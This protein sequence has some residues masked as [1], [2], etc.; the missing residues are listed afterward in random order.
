M[1]VTLFTAGFVE[2][3]LASTELLREYLEGYLS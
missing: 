1:K 2:F 3:W